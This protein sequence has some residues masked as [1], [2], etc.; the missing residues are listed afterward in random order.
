M[1][2]KR[3]GKSRA[4]EKLQ[5]SSA[6]SDKSR[7]GH[8]RSTKHQAP[9]PWPLVLLLFLGANFCV[10]ATA[11]HLASITP[12]GGQ[13][14]TE[15]E[16]S[17]NGDRLQDAEE[18]ICYEPGIEVLKLN[19]ATNKVVKAQLR[20]APGCSMGEHHLRLRA[21]TGIS[22]L[23]TFFVGPYPVVAETEPNNE[24]GKAQKIALNTTVEGVITSEDV[25][26]FA[27]EAKKGQRISVEV[28]GI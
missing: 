15:L 6:N 22:E 20:I 21:A 11:P 4:P 16:V 19:L 5:T 25:D 1:N 10:Q 24:P 14:G 3:R 8:Q 7:A 27:I 28:E 17:F 18:V 23:R 26:C 2:R 9:S 13:R 12:T